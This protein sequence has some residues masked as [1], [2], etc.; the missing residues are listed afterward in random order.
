MSLKGFVRTHQNLYKRPPVLQEYPA[1]TTSV[2]GYMDK[3]QV[4]H[5]LQKAQE[6]SKKRKFEQTVDLV[7]NLRD[8]NVKRTNERVN[9]FIDL[10]HPHGKTVR[11]CGLV[12][13]QL[14]QAAKQH[15][16]TTVQKEE[17][18]ALQADTKRLKKLASN[19]DYFVAQ[20]TIM[21]L[22]A[23]SMGAVLGKKGKTPNPKAGCVV[24][25]TADL[26]AVKKRL[27]KLVKAEAKTEAS[28]KCPVG[29]ESMDKEK[30]AENVMA[31]YNSVK[32]ALPQEEHNI[33]NV[34]LKLTMGPVIKVE[35]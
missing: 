35:K 22:V 29:K 19:H 24:P 15:F 16:D 5:T 27:E 30:I 14:A 33:K 31:V 28:I 32:T 25:P 20:A 34:M 11:V 8:I 1:R 10:P 21:P 9:L 17:F 7:I 3:Q 6:A 26:A 18:D 13:A 23:R 12:D 2:G 4:L